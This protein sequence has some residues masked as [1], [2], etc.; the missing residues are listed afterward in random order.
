MVAKSTRSTK[1]T[2]NASSKSSKVRKTNTKRRRDRASHFCSMC[3]EK[4][5]EPN[6]FQGV[7]KFACFANI[8]FSKGTEDEPK[9]DC[10]KCDTIWP[11]GGWLAEFGTKENFKKQRDA[12]PG[13]QAAFVKCGN[14]WIEA[15]NAGKRCRV[16]NSKAKKRNGGNVLH[17][18]QETRR[19]R[20]R[21]I[22][23]KSQNMRIKTRMKILTPARYEKKYRRTVEQDKAKCRWFR[24]HGKKVW[25]T[26]VRLDPEGEWEAEDEQV[27]GVEEEEELDSGG[28][29]LREGQQEAKF[30][31]VADE[32]GN[33]QDDAVFI[34]E[35]IAAG[36]FENDADD[37]D[38][39]Q[40]DDAPDDS[41][42]SSSERSSIAQPLIACLGGVEEEEATQA[43]QRPSA[44]RGHPKPRGATREGSTRTPKKVPGPRSVPEK[45]KAL[46]DTT[47]KGEALDT[48]E[49]LS[50]AGFAD[51]EAALS[52]K[53]AGLKCDDFNQLAISGASQTALGVAAESI[54][55]EFTKLISNINKAEQ[56][57]K[58]RK[59]V[60]QHAIEQVGELKTVVS[61]ISKLFGSM[62]GVK[63][64]WSSVMASWRAL[65][66]PMRS[67]LKVL[68][69]VVGYIVKREALETVRYSKID[70]LRPLLRI[71]GDEYGLSELVSVDE[72]HN[73][74][75]HIVELI[76]AKVVP[77]AGRNVR[78]P[79]QLAP[80]LRDLIGVLLDLEDPPLAEDHMN[81]LK[82][83]N[84]ALVDAEPLESLA[85]AKTV[86]AGLAKLDVAVVPGYSILAPLVNITS[87]K[88]MVNARSEAA[89]SQ[90]KKLSKS[91][92][93]HIARGAM[94]KLD[95]STPNAVACQSFRKS[96]ATA[97]QFVA[98]LKK[99]SKDIETY[100]AILNGL[101]D[102]VSDSFRSVDDLFRG[103]AI[104]ATRLDVIMKIQNINALFDKLPFE[105]QEFCTAADIYAVWERHR[106]GALERQALMTGLIELGNFESGGGSDGGALSQEE[107]TRK[108][109]FVSKL[110]D[111]L[112]Q[113]CIPLDTEA[114]AAIRDMLSSSALDTQAGEM[115]IVKL[116]AFR[117]KHF[118]KDVAVPTDDDVMDLCRWAQWSATPTFHRDCISSSMDFAVLFKQE[119]EIVE[120][121][122]QSSIDLKG[123]LFKTAHGAARRLFDL[124]AEILTQ[125]IRELFAEEAQESVAGAV[126]TIQA[127]TKNITVKVNS[128]VKET[129]DL[130][131]A[132]N[133]KLSKVL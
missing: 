26:Q 93:L 119:D 55:Q 86:A 74:F 88:N 25:A 84:E 42:A 53:V 82:A 19:I 45:S 76:L 15:H 100:K 107:V 99:E 71:H 85:A 79:E 83:L 40:P 13:V 113:M 1:S 91:R 94:D 70:G 69:R 128:I 104:P 6:Q 38:G 129:G 2:S 130:L 98:T 54:V 77:S 29:E 68:P 124:T 132:E 17:M 125:R 65:P 51:L 7:S 80:P 36:T 111:D 106:I 24:I 59:Y 44:A 23:K 121:L 60:N 118:G 120:L 126:V 105:K 115:F 103:V 89:Q 75:L 9:G 10:L 112:S 64:E 14:V 72:L 4:A 16:Q 78:S 110:R 101:V 37:E 3:G 73:F 114:D 92:S 97:T 18:M 116:G 39:P 133:E 123:A 81:D 117:L 62:K 41:D 57:M 21:I 34:A 102:K 50:L 61:N 87:F 131:E 67:E 35:S 122:K 46:A 52:E 48:D 58:R 8:V 32:I 12:D 28:E 63:T 5:L 66:D 33:M 56:S 22:K 11:L 43:T 31:A 90:I 108:I 47:P 96:L 30:N 20:K 109:G 95:I 27:D 127:L 49:E